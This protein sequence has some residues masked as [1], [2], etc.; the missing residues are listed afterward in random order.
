VLDPQHPPLTQNDERP[1][2][3][4]D[5]RRIGKLIEDHFGRRYLVDYQGADEVNRAVVSHRTV[6]DDLQE[7]L[8]YLLLEDVVT[9]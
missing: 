6:L 1:N 2:A 7:E 8:Q 9:L 5:D 4:H 3:N